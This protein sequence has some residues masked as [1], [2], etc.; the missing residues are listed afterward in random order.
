MQ[1]AL[2]SS[3]RRIRG[4]AGA[5]H[6]GPRE[7]APRFLG[8]ADHHHLRTAGTCTLTKDLYGK[9]KIAVGQVLKYIP[10][11]IE[12]PTWKPSDA[13]PRARSIRWAVSPIDLGIGATFIS[14]CDKNPPPVGTALFT[15][16]IQGYGLIVPKASTQIAL[17]AE[18]GYFLYG[19]GAA[20]QVAPWNN[21]EYIYARPGTKSTA[22]NHGRAD[23]HRSH[24]QIEGQA[25]R[26]LSR[27]CWHRSSARLHPRSPSASW[28]R[29]STTPI[30]T[31]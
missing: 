28:G 10:S 7:E 20:G 15:G 30:G 26:R 14:S 17:T 27:G 5:P 2:Q 3:D 19:F 25:D 16:P 29:R 31:T 11:A 22:L 1:R 18:E 21:D 23:G 12:N 24:H 13:P 8:V 9:I 4:H 6:Q